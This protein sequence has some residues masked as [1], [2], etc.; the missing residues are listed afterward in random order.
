MN[1]PIGLLAG[2]IDDQLTPSRTVGTC[3]SR[4]STAQSHIAKR[5]ITVPASLVGRDTGMVRHHFDIGAVSVSAI[6]VI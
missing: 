3:V 4:I 1:G 6:F 5:A 2:W